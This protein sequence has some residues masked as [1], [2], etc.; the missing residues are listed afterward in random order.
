MEIQNIRK[1]LPEIGWMENI[2]EGHL[3]YEA[4][5]LVRGERATIVKQLS[6]DGWILSIEESYDETP[7][8]EWVLPSVDACKAKA[9]EWQVRQ[10]AEAFG[11]KG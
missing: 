6:G 3:H 5:D 9:R 7:I 8:A 2:Y 4:F 11:L 10:M 1:D